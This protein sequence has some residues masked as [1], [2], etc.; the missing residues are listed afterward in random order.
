M[1]KDMA[2]I[3]L[4]PAKVGHRWDKTGERMNPYKKLSLEDKP[5]TESMKISKGGGS[6]YSSINV[7][8]LKRW[9]NKQVG[10][11]WDE[12]YKEVCESLRHKTIKDCIGHDL[13]E[14]IDWYII[15][16]VKMI[17]NVPHSQGYGGWH[18]IGGHREELYVH[19][20]TK[21]ICKYKSLKRAKEVKPET[22]RILKTFGKDE[23]PIES[24]VPFVKLFID[25][26]TWH[27]AIEKIDGI[28]YFV[29]CYRYKKPKYSY[30]TFDYNNGGTVYKRQLSKKEMKKYGVKND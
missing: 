29:R 26:I 2:D 15:K 22:F 25:P 3:M 18:P 9:L 24:T 10:R 7:T 1:R 27:E 17:D 23:L 20:S 30:Y 6:R 5:C 4:E 14:I 21:L 11:H 13:V 28:W 16:D 12:V 19:P 8:P